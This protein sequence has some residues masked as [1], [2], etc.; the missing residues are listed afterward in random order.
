[1]DSL[2][3]TSYYTPYAAAWLA[4]VALF[5]LARRLRRSQNLN[6]PPGPKPWPIIGNLNLIGTLPHR[7]IHDLSQQY[8]EI[9]QLKFGSFNVVVGSSVEMAKVFLKTMDV[10]FACRPKTA[11]G[12]YTTYNYSDITWSPY[13]A[14][15]RQARKMCLMELF[16]VKRLE[17]YEYIRVEETNSLVKSIF[18]SAGEE[19]P[20]KDLLSTVSLNVISR[21]VLGKRYLDE[22]SNSVVSPDEFKKMLDELF[23][24]NGVF[25]IGDSIPWID[26]MDLQGYVKRMKTVSKK[27]DRFL[28]HVLDEH[29][30]RRKAAG[31]K[32]EA[33]DMVDLLLQLADDPNLDVKL[34][35]HGVKAFT[36]DLL[37]GGTESSAVTVEWA[38][39]ELL[40]KPEIFQ[41]AIEELDRVIGKDKWVSEKDMPN[42]PY[43]EAIAKETMRLH[44]VAP[45]LVPRRARE[46][47]KV[48]GY[49]ITEGT[50]VLVSVWSIGRDPKLWEK[51]E[52][53]YPE[54]FIGKEID[55][56]GH[57]FE[58]LPFGAGR[59]MCP[60]YSLGLK[61][62]E[63]TL[64]NLLHGF[65]WKLPKTMS[66]NDL[67]MEEI[68]G[69]STPKKIPL[70]TVAQPRLP[71]EMYRF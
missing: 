16:S 43:I 37:A 23:L 32:F 3:S 63:S 59:R 33:K 9:M 34:E 57:D 7:S 10:N 56:K 18:E 69:L 35:R 24:L 25:N 2:S 38:I 53:F 36:Q 39:A 71:V 67:N 70:L 19:I 54:R 20:L 27:F 42:L 6:P 4:T 13:G 55:V 31:E 62:I 15:W 26:F 50:R 5:L 46:N 41:K 47:C 29:N 49:D 28:E 17:S 1:M 68:F 52:E 51:P 8:G 48:A 40:K 44:P 11:A 30:E 66:E 22:E 12:K 58:L 45:M 64:A 21:M 65:Y 61:V 14:Y 60:G